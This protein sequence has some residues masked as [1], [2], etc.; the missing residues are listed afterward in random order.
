MKKK[1]TKSMNL[2]EICE[3]NSLSKWVHMQLTLNIFFGMRHLDYKT[4]V[5]ITPI[6][7]CRIARI[8]SL[9]DLNTSMMKA[10]PDCSKIKILINMYCVNQ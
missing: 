8:P 10:W 4:V 6:A 5:Y 7:I 1:T 9:T 2:V 3:M